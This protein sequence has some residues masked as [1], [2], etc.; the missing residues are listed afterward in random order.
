MLLDE[1][2]EKDSSLDRL[3]SEVQVQ[4]EKAKKIA[5]LNEE[6]R[7]LIEQERTAYNEERGKI[8][9]DV[10]QLQKQHETKIKLIKNKLLVLVSSGDGGH[11]KSF[12]NNDLSIDELIRKVSDCVYSLK[13]QSQSHH[14]L[15]YNQ[16][17]DQYLKT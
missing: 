15:S 12:D 13:K 1:I 4:G 5:K 11:D 14:N 7:D 3:D 10:E 16:S 8:E 2:R 17:R 9:N 6:L